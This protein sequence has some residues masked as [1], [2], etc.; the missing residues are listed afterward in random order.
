MKTNLLQDEKFHPL[1]SQAMQDIG[2]I[3]SEASGEDNEDAF[4]QAIATACIS[5]QNLKTLIK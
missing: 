2:V 4:N 3:L 5:L 1:W